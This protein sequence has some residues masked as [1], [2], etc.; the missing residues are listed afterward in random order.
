MGFVKAFDMYTW[1]VVTVGGSLF[2]HH[3][4][5][6]PT[7]GNSYMV[8]DVITIFWNVLTGIM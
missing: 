2:I 4:T 3:K 7:T 5:V 8:G 6:N 1:A